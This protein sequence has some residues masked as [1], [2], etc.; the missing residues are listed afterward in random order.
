LHSDLL[1][2]GA[3]VSTI[4]NSLAEELVKQLGDRQFY[5]A[6]DLHTFGLFQTLFA[7][8]EALKQRK[9]SYIRVTPRRRL[10]PKAAVLK[11]LR[12]NLSEDQG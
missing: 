8:R 11:Y 1:T 7:A 6:R 10:I 3:A 9:I 4:M 12:D 5:T 2:E